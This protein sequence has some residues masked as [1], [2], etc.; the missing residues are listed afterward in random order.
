MNRWISTCLVIAA[1]QVGCAS[2]QVDRGKDLSTAGIAYSRATASV[3]DMAMDA[4]VD[5]SS[6]TRLPLAARPAQGAEAEARKA[7]LQE[8]DAELIHNVRQYAVLKRSV[9]AV[10]GYFVA[11]QELSGATPGDAAEASLKTLADRVNGVSTALG[12]EARLSEERKGAIAALGK[13][14]VKQAHGAAIARALERDAQ[15]IGRALALQHVVL[16]VSAADVKAQADAEAVVFH[17]ERIVKPYLAGGVGQAWVDDRRA[18]IK[19][20]ALGNAS[21]ALQTAAQAAQQMED[22]WARILSGES[23][24][25]EL[26][27][28][29]RDV[30]EALDAAAALK[31]SL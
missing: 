2:V 30:N 22:V 5:V 27:L 23:S 21:T 20:T 7:K 24:G 10:E 13:V 26:M 8:I 12:G 15:T 19:A 11:L 14:L 16:Q 25:K 6:Q 31:K 28:V 18:Y 9:S 1:V 4:I 29:L 17:R 3:I